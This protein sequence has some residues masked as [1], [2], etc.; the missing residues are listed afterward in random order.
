G[1]KLL[2][3]R[4]RAALRRGSALGGRS[5]TRPG[6]DRE[7]KDLNG[8]L[9][10]RELV[11]PHRSHLRGELGQGLALSQTTRRWLGQAEGPVPI[12]RGRRT[13]RRR[14]GKMGHPA[15]YRLLRNRQSSSSSFSGKGRLWAPEPGWASLVTRQRPSGTRRPTTKAWKPWASSPRTIPSGS[16]VAMRRLPEEMSPAGS[17]PKASQIARVSGRTGSRSI[18][19]STPTP[20][21]AASSRQAP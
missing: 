18:Q 3:H 15:G 12:S 6:P 7:G 21:A 20:E 5:D 17:R 16:G 11:R 4:R 19:S 1:G 14:G 8:L 9:A 2:P 10:R 13:G